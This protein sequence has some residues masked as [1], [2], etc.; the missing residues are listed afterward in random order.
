MR[1]KEGR[2]REREKRKWRKEVTAA[3]FLL[4][5]LSLTLPL[6]L[7][8]L[9]FCHRAAEVA[10]EEEEE[11]RVHDT[12]KRRGRMEGDDRTRVKTLHSIQ[13]N[14]LCLART[15]ASVETQ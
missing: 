2:E 1:S 9:A 3:V 10:A 5:S 14:G 7:F 12:E 4:V 6:F 8:S 15:E 11:K 13:Q